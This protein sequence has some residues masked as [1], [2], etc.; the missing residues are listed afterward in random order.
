VA[1]DPIRSYMWI[2]LAAEAGDQTA[3]SNRKLIETRLT[4]EELGSAQ[5][6]TRRWRDTHR[7]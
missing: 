4:R 3:N 6:L 7:A 1:R 5:L 2:T